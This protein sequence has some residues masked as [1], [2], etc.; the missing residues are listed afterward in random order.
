MITIKQM[1]FKKILSIF[2]LIIFLYSPISLATQDAPDIKSPACM[3]IES[4]T[5]KTIYEKNSDQ[6]MYPASTTKLMTAILTVENCKL[7]DIATVSHNAVFSIP[8]G[9]SSASL[10]VGEELTIEQ[11]LNVLL[12]PSANDAA[13][14]LAEHIAGSVQSFS[15]MMNTKAIEIGCTNTNFVNPNGIHDENHVSTA[16]DLTLIGNYALKYPEIQNI[17]KK[18]TYQLPVTNKYD[19][20]DRIFNTTNSL[21]KENHSTKPSNY[22]Y[23]YATGLKTGYTEPA[24]HCVVASAEKDG[25]TYVATIL[26]GK[27]SEDYLDERFLDAKTLFEYAFTNYSVKKL[28]TSD[29]IID[30]IVISHA[31]NE[32][33]NLKIK[34]RGDINILLENSV[35][36]KAVEPEIEYSVDLEAPISEN[37]ILG[38]ATYTVDNVSCT[39]DIL[40]ANSVDRIDIMPIILKIVLGIF[41][42]LLG[43]I[44]IR[45]SSRPKRNRRVK[46]KRKH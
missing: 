29:E 35:S 26:G 4:S 1:K 19:K 6:V 16:H 28:H 37:T 3:I 44:F 17:V 45:L 24:G 15:S 23:E 21:I 12:I 34:L 8:T 36:L 22:Y 39:S 27:T 30:S 14:V 5:G 46:R 32:T 7:T 25:V 9:Y 38:T 2:F 13:I 20:D 40:A 11:L 43:L 42:I 41:I 18:N 10:Q 33:K 31:T